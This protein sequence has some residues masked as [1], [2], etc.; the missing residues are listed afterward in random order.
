LPKG[1]YTLTLAIP[2][3]HW[4][5]TKGVTT[6]HSLDFMLEFIPHDGG[7][8]DESNFAKED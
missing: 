8:S 7:F 4:F 3:A 5:L 6:C 1:E 2:Q